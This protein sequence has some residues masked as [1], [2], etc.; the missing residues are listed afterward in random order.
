MSWGAWSKEFLRRL[1]WPAW[2]RSYLAIDTETT[3]LEP[4]LDLAYEIGTQLVVAGRPVQRARLLLDWTREEQVDLGWLKRRIALLE[5]EF[6]R[7]GRLQRPVLALMAKG[8]PAREVLGEVRE[9]LRDLRKRDLPLL[10]HNLFFDL[11]FLGSHF[12][13]DLGEKLS[14]EGWTLLDTGLL[15]KASQQHPNPRAWPQPGE[16]SYRYFQRMRGWRVKGKWSLGGACLPK[17][18]LEKRGV[19]RAKL[20]RADYDA[21]ATHVL[22]EAMTTQPATARP[23]AG[24]ARQRY[25]GQR[26]R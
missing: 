2:P 7:Q 15:E 5:I 20:H 8:R 17:Y 9:L 14:F 21:W 18:H 6:G 3:G 11:G 25:R 19:E 24:T 1:G 22:Y 26:I 16:D 4:Q 13:R 23:L 10:G 12:A